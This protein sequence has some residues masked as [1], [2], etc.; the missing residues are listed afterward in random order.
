MEYFSLGVHHSGCSK[1]QK[2]ETHIIKYVYLEIKPMEIK[3][4]TQM[5]TVSDS[6]YSTPVEIKKQKKLGKQP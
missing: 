3:E 6:K 1:L 4:S 2:F 5:K